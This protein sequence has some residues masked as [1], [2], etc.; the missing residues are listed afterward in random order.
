MDAI[1]HAIQP[2][3]ALRMS[4][5]SAIQCNPVQSQYIIKPILELYF[6]MLCSAFAN[7]SEGPLLLKSSAVL[8]P[9]SAAKCPSRTQCTE[10]HR[11]DSVWRVFFVSP[12]KNE[13]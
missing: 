8:P 1:E 3:D 10:Y 11:T 2:L 5:P 9:L 4:N 6:K 13:L 12:S 7:S